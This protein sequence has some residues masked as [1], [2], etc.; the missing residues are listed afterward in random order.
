MNQSQIELLVYPITPPQIA[1][2]AH[3]E[4]I[5]TFHRSTLRRWWEQDKFPRPQKI[6]GSLVWHIDTIYDWIEKNVKTGVSHD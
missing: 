4:K 3:L 2:I 1:Q 6:N 5:T